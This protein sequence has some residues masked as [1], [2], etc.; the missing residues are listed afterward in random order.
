MSLQTEVI[1]NLGQL[2]KSTTSA[3]ILLTGLSQNELDELGGF[4]SDG[5]R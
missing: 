1:N 2:D 5:N 4:G 3:V